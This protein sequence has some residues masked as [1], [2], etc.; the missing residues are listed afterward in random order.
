MPLEV[1]APTG[2]FRDADAQVRGQKPGDAE[3]EG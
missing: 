3:P 2:R 1:L